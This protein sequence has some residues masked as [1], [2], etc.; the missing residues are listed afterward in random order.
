MPVKRL[1]SRSVSQDRLAE[2]RDQG[3]NSDLLLA[4][5]ALVDDEGMRKDLAKL[6]GKERVYPSLLPTQASL[7]WST[8]G[9]NLPGFQREFWT[10]HSGIIRP[11][12]G[13][14]WLEWDW[15]GIEAR[16]FT[17]Y[18][19]DEEDV[20][21][22][23]GDYDIHTE[24]CKKYLFEWDALPSDWQ[25]SGDE[26][27]VRAKNFRYGVLQYGSGEQA[28]LGMPGVERL[29]LDK[30]VLVQ[31]A[32]HFLSAR[33]KAQAWKDK[34]WAACIKDKIARTFMGHRRLLFGD[35]DTRKKEGLNHM[36]QGSVANLMAWCLIEILVKTWPSAALILNKHDGATLAFPD[37]L[38]QADV[39][40]RVKALVER[41]WEVGQGVTM[42]FPA[43]WKV[44]V[45]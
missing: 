27:R 18:T 22:F 2:L 40:P 15:K 33:P 23:T 42:G 24:T 38:A 3:A 31:R 19:G 17:A 1:G 13:E 34:V 39:V 7:R 37:N 36:I 11:D 26:R 41:E 43:S 30:Q 8:K 32:R 9:P 6:K 21:W 25:G 4:R 29:G 35:D 10:Q 44:R 5:L 45:A 16:M 12:S 28:I 14:W 20:R